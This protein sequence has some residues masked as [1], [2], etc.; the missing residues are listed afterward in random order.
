M[1]KRMK[2][3]E[4]ARKM[5]AAERRY[6][7]RI[8]PQLHRVGLMFFAIIPFMMIALFSVVMFSTTMAEA[9]TVRSVFY[10]SDVQKF[11]M[12]AM[13]MTVS[14]LPIA[15]FF[16]M[17]RMFYRKPENDS[18][19]FALSG[20]FESGM[21]QDG[22]FYT[23]D[24]VTVRVPVEWLKQLPEDGTYVEAVAFPMRPYPAIIEMESKESSFVLSTPGTKT[25]PSV[26][27]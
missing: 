16:W 21:G 26:A 11:W 8:S 6:V 22:N 18:L 7:N 14:L 9:S 4:I 3:K 23:I 13:V 25:Q 5:N 17:Y 15:L 2:E 19:T 1:L 27:S 10:T 24:G 20:T 12:L